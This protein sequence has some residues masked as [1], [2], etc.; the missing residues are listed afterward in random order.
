MALQNGRLLTFPATSAPR[1]TRTQSIE[2][3]SALLR[4][5]CKLSR[6]HPAAFDYIERLTRKALSQRP[7]H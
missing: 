5:L 2:A 4:D 6:E 1:T 3:V 7:R